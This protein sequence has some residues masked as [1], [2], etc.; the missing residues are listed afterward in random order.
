MPNWVWG[1][2][3]PYRLCSPDE[4]AAQ[5]WRPYLTN[6]TLRRVSAQDCSER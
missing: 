2:R 4:M 1:S 3:T 5:T 6:A